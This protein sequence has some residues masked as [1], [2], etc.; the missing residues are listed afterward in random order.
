M[1]RFAFVST[2]LALALTTSAFAADAD[3]MLRRPDVSADTV[4]FVYDNDIW[5]VSKDGGIALPLSSPEGR[6]SSPKFSPDGREIAFSAN[7]DGN[8]EVYTIPVE[9]GSVKRLTYHPGGDGVIDY[10]PDGRVIFSAYRQM[11][12]PSGRLF[13]ADHDG[14]L[15]EALPMAYAQF[16]SVSPDGKTIAFT[17]WSREGRSWNRYQGGLAT[18]IWLLDFNTLEAK[19]ITDHPGTDDLPMFHGNTVYYLSDAGVA[20]RRNIWAYDTKSGDRRQVTH[21]T[22]HDVMWPSI[23]PQDIVFENGGKLHLLDLATEATRQLKVT[24]PGDHPNIR[25]E[26]TDVG[27]YGSPGTIS[28]GAKRMAGSFR[29]DIWTLPAENGYKQN[30]TRTNGIAERNPDWS[31]DG[32]WIAFFSDATGEYQLFMMKSDGSEEAVQLA[33]GYETFFYNP[34]WAPDSK[35]LSFSDKAGNIYVHLLD[36]SETF[37][38]DKDPHAGQG[39]GVD[40]AQD[41]NWF[42]YSIGDADNGNSV[43]KLYDL[44]NRAAHQVTSAMFP[45]MS[46]TFDT[47]GDYLFFSTHRNF[48]ASYSPVG[49]WGDHFFVDTMVLA[50]VPLRADI[51]S[52]FAPENDAEEIEEDEEADKAEEEDAKDSE[53]TDDDES[54]EGGEGDEDEEENDNWVIDLE[55]F[56]GRARQLPVGGGTFYNL[57]GAK[58]KLFFVKREGS[59]RG[60][61]TVIKTYDLDETEETEVLAD[62]GG[63]TLTP[64]R[65]KMAVYARGGVYIT[66]AGPGA[67]LDKRVDTGN[68]Q[69]LIDPAEEWPQIVTDVWR[70][71]R[72]FFYDPGMHGVDWD[73][74]L[75]RA[76]KMIKHAANREDV[77]YV[78][79]LMVAELNVGHAYVGGPRERGKSLGVGVLG[80][81]FEAATDSAGNAGYRISRIY[82][83][84]EWDLDM[85]GPLDMPGIEVNEGDFLLAVNGALLADGLSPYAAFAGLGGQTVELTLSDKTVFDDTA[86]KV[87]V[88][89][90]TSDYELRLRHWIE[91]NRKYVYEQSGGSIGYIYVRNTSSGGFAD[92]QRQF[93]GQYTMDG[94]IIDER[95]NGGGLSP[96]RMVEMLNRPIHNY[97]AI[98]DGISWRTPRWAHAGPKAMLINHAA[99][100]GGD[101]F[102]YIFKQLEVGPL[103]GTRTWGGLVGLNGNPGSIDQGYSSV[104]RF[105]IYDLDQTWAVEGHGVD[106]DIEVIDDPGLLAKGIDPQ[107]DAAIDWVL[108]AIEDNPPV[109]HLEK[110]AYPD[111]S[112]QGVPVEDH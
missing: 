78:I 26:L 74:Q 22:A 69:T 71:Y 6:E 1:F 37:I 94:L 34:Q 72:D 64:D 46:P 36:E 100:S 81:D 75:A 55:G 31:P 82:S 104:P 77:T 112:G 25:A 50:Y 98:R 41:S 44:A 79:S 54:D 88:K 21:F 4:A 45:S 12:Y 43:V 8:T 58:H 99:G 96:H 33:C 84:A 49:D 32:K 73:A 62:A 70:I 39:L 59:G 60:G 28:P 51:E 5:V 87:L 110:P 106:P 103:I 38:A 68:M 57:V 86:R 15:P 85:H 83:G 7:Y 89:T 65:K 56:E 13:F 91:Q 66:K 52:P 29:G 20:N 80:C 40:W 76:L 90:V 10:H 108:K 67:K 48:R 111:R 101:S 93:I 23:G 107:L 16:A 18:D 42:A 95:W 2:L 17:P 30:L 14:G 97:W 63:F 19:Q 102:P 92:M 47:E 35:K 109:H 53:E 3:Y 61:K 105:A 9:G 24:I 11:K 27:G